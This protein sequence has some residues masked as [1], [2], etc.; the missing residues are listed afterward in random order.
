MKCGRGAVMHLND[1]HFFLFSIIQGVGTNNYVE[2]LSLK[3]LMLFTLEKG[4][5]RLQFFGDSMIIVNWIK[6]L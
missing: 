6:E 5:L 4:C 3:Y 2:L 1:D